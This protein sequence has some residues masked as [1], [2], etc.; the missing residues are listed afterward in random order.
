MLSST[1][2]ITKES[3]KIVWT[4]YY[5]KHFREI[6]NKL[7]SSFQNYQ[8]SPNFEVRVKCYASR[9][10]NETALVTNTKDVLK[11]IAYPLHVLNIS[12]E[13]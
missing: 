1:S 13:L 10:G 8:Y 9:S 3:V 4:K 12:E 2:N 5:E 6:K 7:S 11:P